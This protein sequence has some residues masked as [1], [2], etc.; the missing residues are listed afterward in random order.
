MND[1]DRDKT[2]LTPLGT[3]TWT[4]TG[5]RLNGQPATRLCVVCMDP[6]PPE[7]FKYCS[8]ACSRID[9]E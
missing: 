5:W 9:N 4:G 1:T 3:W 2:V 6:L 7:H 8:A